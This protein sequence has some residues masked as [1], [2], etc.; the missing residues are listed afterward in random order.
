[1]SFSIFDFLPL[2]STTSQCLT[3]V[4]FAWAW[5]RLDT[6]TLP[7][8]APQNRLRNGCVLVQVS[9]V[10]FSN[11]CP[12]AQQLP[13]ILLWSV[14]HEHGLVW[15]PARSLNTLHK[16]VYETVMFLARYV[17]FHFRLFALMFCNFSVSYCGSFRMS[18]G[19]FRYL[20]AP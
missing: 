16:T 15:I 2:Y 7:E 13:S 18:V 3:V 12:Y 19:S 11:F 6:C 5:A 4:R 17:I 14:L 1:M 10:L 8:H 9:Q 20:H